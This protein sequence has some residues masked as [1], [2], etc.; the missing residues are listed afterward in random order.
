MP[1]HKAFQV[2]DKS[3]QKGT[4]CIQDVHQQSVT[5]SGS[6][7]RA[8]NHARRQ[9]LISCQWKKP[10]PWPDNFKEELSLPSLKRNACQQDPRPSRAQEAGAWSGTGPPILDVAATALIQ[11]VKFKTSLWN[12]HNVLQEWHTT[13]WRCFLLQTAPSFIYGPASLG[14]LERGGN[15]SALS[16]SEMVFITKTWSD[17]KGKKERRE[18]GT[19]NWWTTGIGVGTVLG[20]SNAQMTRQAYMLLKYLGFAEAHASCRTL[21]CQGGGQSDKWCRWREIGVCFG[22]GPITVWAAKLK[23]EY[24]YKVKCVYHV[25]EEEG[26]AQEPAAFSTGGQPSLTFNHIYPKSDVQ[27]RKHSQSLEK[28][29]LRALPNGTIV[30]SLW[31]LWDLS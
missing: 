27:V 17:G 10:A 15:N 12:T 25:Q 3:F 11:V 23:N 8:T 29:G 31:Q 26:A 28:L 7:P 21:S 4:A 6:I 30:T 5:P 19:K 2:V 1:A 14:S 24:A 20:Q 16:V 22:G 13:W 9:H 18:Q